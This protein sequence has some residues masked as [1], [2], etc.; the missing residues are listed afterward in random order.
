MLLKTGE[1]ASSKGSGVDMPNTKSAKKRLRQNLERRA[2]NRAVKSSLKSHIRKVREAATS[3]DATKAEAAYRIACKRL[4]QA[5]AKGI[6]HKNTASRHKSRLS[7]RLKGGQP[8][9]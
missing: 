6:I 5:A 9:A 7:V 4:D 2:R 1:Q 8:A 3:G